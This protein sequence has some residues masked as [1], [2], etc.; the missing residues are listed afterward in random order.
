[1]Q[2]NFLDKFN[3]YMNNPRP[4]HIFIYL[5]VDA[6]TSHGRIRCAEFNYHYFCKVL[7]IIEHTEFY[8]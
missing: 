3:G 5:I 8:F 7:G 2:N 4:L 6:F 1:M